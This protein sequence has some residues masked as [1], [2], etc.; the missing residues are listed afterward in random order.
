VVLRLRAPL[1][2][3]DLLRLLHQHIVVHCPHQQ[4]DLIA[5][6]RVP[7]AGLQHLLESIRG[8]QVFECLLQDQVGVLV[9]GHLTHALHGVAAAPEHYAPLVAVLLW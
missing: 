5:I 2:E 8:A 1:E 7:E 6:A 4:E 3:A 9:V